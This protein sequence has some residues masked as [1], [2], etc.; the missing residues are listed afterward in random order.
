MSRAVAPIVLEDAFLGNRA[1]H[2]PILLGGVGDVLSQG[3]NDVD[4]GGLREDL[5]EFLG[6]LSGAGMSARNIWR[7]KENA[8][9]IA[10]NSLSRLVGGAA[11]QLKNALKGERSLFGK[12]RHIYLV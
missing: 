4:L 2:P 12:P 3:R 1:E 11:R 6:N 5:V 9:R 7:E 8:L 10:T